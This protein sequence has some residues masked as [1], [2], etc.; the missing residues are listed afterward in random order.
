[1]KPPC[2]GSLRSLT[3]D[4]PPSLIA[5]RLLPAIRERTCYTPFIPGCLLLVQSRHAQC[6]DECPLL[7]AKRTLTN[8]RLP[9]SIMST[10]LWGWSRHPGSTY[11]TSAFDPKRTLRTFVGT[12]GTSTRW[13]RLRLQPRLD[14][15]EQP[16]AH[17]VVVA[18]E[19][20]H[21]AHAT[22]L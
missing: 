2:A 22:V 21:E 18:L 9:I 19:R 1:M 4:S 8:R 10:R 13:A 6:A 17:R 11:A 16:E 15:P 3:L 5:G 20:D 12:W 14:G 7:G